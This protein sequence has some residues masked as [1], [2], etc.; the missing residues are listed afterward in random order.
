MDR[1]VASLLAKTI[2]S[3]MHVAAESQAAARRIDIS[4]GFQHAR[5]AALDHR[6]DRRLAGRTARRNWPPRPF[7]SRLVGEQQMQPFVDADQRR[8]ARH[9]ILA[10]SRA[11]AA[12]DAI[13]RAGRDPEQARRLGVR[14]APG[15]GER[16]ERLERDLR[17]PRPVGLYGEGLR[18]GGQLGGCIAGPAAVA[19]RLMTTICASFGE[20]SIGFP[21]PLT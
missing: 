15:L 13:E 3:R 9:L 14:Q 17:E 16:P 18:F 12:L 2:L 5:D 19:S 21:S 6:L 1:R 7:V 10:Q 8:D 20:T 4:A 11:I